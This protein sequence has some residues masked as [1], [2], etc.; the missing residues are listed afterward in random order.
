MDYSEKG[1]FWLNTAERVKRGIQLKKMTKC[2]THC[3]ILKVS[4]AVFCSR[5][6]TQLSFFL[7]ILPDPLSSIIGRCTLYRLQDDSLQVNI[8]KLP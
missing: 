6:G 8:S 1:Y 4:F 3:K 7:Y 5:I 2:R